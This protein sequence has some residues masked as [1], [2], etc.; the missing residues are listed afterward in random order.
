MSILFHKF[1]DKSCTFDDSISLKHFQAIKPLITQPLPEIPLYKSSDSVINTTLLKLAPLINLFYVIQGGLFS[2]VK[3]SDLE[4]FVKLAR[5]L[6]RQC[7]RRLQNPGRH[8][9]SQIIHE[10]YIT[11][12]Q[13]VDSFLSIAESDTTLSK[14]SDH[15]SPHTNIT[16][17]PVTCIYQLPLSFPD[18]TI[19]DIKGN[20]VQNLTRHYYP[21]TFLLGPLLRTVSFLAFPSHQFLFIYF[22]LFRVRIEC[23]SLFSLQK[24]FHIYY[25]TGRSK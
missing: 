23:F 14:T 17:G 10:Q 2:R 20:T 11:L 22:L 13:L 7:N 18:L 6:K 8:H 16:H 19:I 24:C 9:R 25:P 12:Q 21:Y 4:K 5:H 1:L 3:I 15:L